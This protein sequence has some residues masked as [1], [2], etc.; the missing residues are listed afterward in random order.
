MTRVVLFQHHGMHGAVPAAQIVRL[1][2]EKDA[3]PVALATRLWPGEPPEDGQLL[4][5][6]CAECT[7]SLWCRHV[8]LHE[9]DEA[10]TR[11]LPGLLREILHDMP[12]VVGAAWIDET[13]YWLVDLSRLVARKA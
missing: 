2:T 3:D 10:P 4:L 5:F 9:L 12:H 1:G 7:R 11:P 13:M 8:N 6:R